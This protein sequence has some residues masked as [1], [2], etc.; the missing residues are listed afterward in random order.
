MPEKT[1]KIK[2]EITSEDLMCGSCEF[3]DNNLQCCTIFL[4]SIKI[5]RVQECLDG[6][7]KAQEESI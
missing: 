7:I 4:Q 2:I 5:G 6:E 1:R 3:A